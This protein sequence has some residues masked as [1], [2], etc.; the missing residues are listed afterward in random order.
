MRLLSWCRKQ[1]LCRSLKRQ[2]GNP[3][4]IRAWHC[5]RLKNHDDMKAPMKVVR[6]NVGKSNTNIPQNL[7]QRVKVPSWLWAQRKRPIYKSSVYRAIFIK[8]TTLK[9][10]YY[11]GVCAY[12]QW[13]PLYPPWVPLCR[14]WENRL[15]QADWLMR[16]YGFEAEEILPDDHPFWIWLWPQIGLG[17]S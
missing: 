12:A 11:S 3:H 5:L 7:P 8:N 9:R 17:D 14:W 15:Y 10:V 16:F 6:T 2:Y 13:Q 1:D 4:Q